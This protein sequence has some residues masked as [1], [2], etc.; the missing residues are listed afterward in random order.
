MTTETLSNKINEYKEK[1]FKDLI[2]LEFLYVKHVKDFIENVEKELQRIVPN[3][4]REL[5]EML[6]RLAGEKLI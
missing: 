5:N 4:S 1:D 3:H 2:F 6:R